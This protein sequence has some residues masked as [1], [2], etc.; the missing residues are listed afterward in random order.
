M[1][2]TRALMLAGAF[3]GGAAG[4]WAAASRARRGRFCF[5]DRVVLISGGSRG[6]GLVLARQFAAE[7]SR[8]ALAARNEHE[9]N[10]AADEL[11]KSG[12]EVLALACDVRDREQVNEAVHRTV[13]RYG[14]LDVLINNAGIIQVGPFE[15]MTVSDFEDSLAVHLFGPLYFTLA[16]RAHLRRS[17]GGGRMV[18]I[19][20]VGG[21]IAV[22]HLLPYT[23]G[24]FALTGF[25]EGLRAELKRRN[26]F[27]TTVCPGLMRTGSP[28]NAIFKGKHRLEYAWFAISDSLPLLSV[29]AERA[30]RRIIEA[31]R[32]GQS[33]LVI[34]AQTKAAVLLNEVFPG[35]SAAVRA[36]ANRLL[37]GPGRAGRS[38][39]TGERSN[40]RLADGWLT[41][42]SNTAARRNNELFAH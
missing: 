1:R 23:V 29:D 7:G 34:G 20:S 37:P 16:A 9:L 41:R 31:C 5:R 32:R 13:A 4:G 28:R 10:A 33:R 19:S 8:L 30:A 39:W 38:A 26:T 42:A 6:L 12:A 27:V 24:K 40:S 17:P 11:R 36:F 21:K 25:S 14:R 22:P 18:N 15:H 2:S 3:L 35:A